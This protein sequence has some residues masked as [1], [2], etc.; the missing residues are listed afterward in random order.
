M[1]SFDPS[2][3]PLELAEEELRAPLEAA[4]IKLIDPANFGNTKAPWA[5]L[6]AGP[7]NV[8]SRRTAVTVTIFAQRAVEVHAQVRIA[9][10]RRTVRLII[11]ST[12]NALT[13]VGSGPA[14]TVNGYSA[15]T[16]EAFY[17]Y[18]F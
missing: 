6:H 13:Y 1:A 12:D 14:A 18:V 10:L 15:I 16:L 5:T 3:N 9:E 17:P 4:G 2:R 8:G 11:E 7:E